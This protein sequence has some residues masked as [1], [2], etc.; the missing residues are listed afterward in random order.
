MGVWGTSIFSDDN[1]CDVRDD[2]R[3]MIGDGLD[4]PQATDQL[5]RQWASLEGDPHLA[6]TFW[7]ALAVTQWKCGRLEDRVR[8]KALCVIDDGSALHPWRGSHLERKRAAV[9]E[10]AR[11]QLLLRQPPV[12]KIAKQFR[13]SCDWE[14]G[15][16]ITYRLLSGNFV[17]FQVV[18]FHRDAGGVAPICE[19]IDWQGSQIPRLSELEGLSMRKQISLVFKNRPTRHRNEARPQYRL[20]IGQASKRE[21]P[22]DRVFQLNARL[23][24]QHPPKPRNVANPTTVSLWRYLD[25]TLET[26]YG[27]R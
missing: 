17:V 9:L 20:M 2:Y 11:N 24:I 25:R 22:K 10:A 14:H 26:C 12:R 18:E 1:A 3:R 23:P 4:G 7:L 6:A 21:F 15:E 16:L 13:T 27:L 5:L 19:I 8:E